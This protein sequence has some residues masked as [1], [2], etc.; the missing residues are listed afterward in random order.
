MALARSEMG[1][2]EVCAG[3]GTCQVRSAGGDAQLVPVHNTVTLKLWGEAEMGREWWGCLGK[4]GAWVVCYGKKMTAEAW[5]SSSPK[6]Q[7]APQAVKEAV[8]L[9]LIIPDPTCF[10]QLL[11]E[12]GPSA[13]ASPLA[14]PK[15]I[16]Q[17]TVRGSSAWDWAQVWFPKPA[18]QCC[19]ERR[20]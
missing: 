12:Q 13:A 2:A 3:Q 9:R 7:T 10:S 14:A 16:P 11:A 18:W 4:Q 19:K 15:A 20:H 8:G 17:A 1:T 6:A 5:R